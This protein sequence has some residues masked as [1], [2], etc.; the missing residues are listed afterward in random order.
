MLSAVEMTASNLPQP[1]RSFQVDALP[2]HVFTPGEDLARYMALTVRD[3]LIEAIQKKGRAAA[4][5]ATGNSQ[6]RFLK[7]LVEFGGVDWSKVTLFHMDEY[8]GIRGDHPASFRRYMRERVESLVQPKAFH[9]LAGDCELPLDECERYS[10]LLDAQPIDL[11][12]MGVG[13]NGHLAFNDPPVAR[14]DDP[15]AVKL[16]RLDDACKWQ[17][18]KEGHFPSLEAVPP[19]AFTLTI[20]ALFRATKVLC[21][22]PE[23]RKSQP[24]K[25]ALEGPVST[26]CPASVLRSHSHATLLLDLDSAALLSTP[27]AS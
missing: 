5:L 14:F 15:H 19:Y 7:Q 2:V 1:I 6:I 24:I 21:L 27:P 25:N 8:L 12:C 17:Q 20:P 11:C 26:A 23:K 18:V 13:E 22:A 16:V 3:L 10:R 4:I 9:Y